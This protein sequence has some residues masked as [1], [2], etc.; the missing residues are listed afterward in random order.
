MALSRDELEAIIK[1]GES[2]M[3]PDGRCVTHIDALPSAVEL[4]GDDV[5]KKQHA[6][7]DLEAMRAALDKQIAEARSFAPP[8]TKKKEAPVKTAPAE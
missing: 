8:E 7:G 6:I 4:A 2:V 5:V 3:L 1:R